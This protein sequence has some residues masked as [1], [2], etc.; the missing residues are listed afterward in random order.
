MNSSTHLLPFCGRGLPG[1]QITHAQCEKVLSPLSDQS[2][3]RDTGVPKPD[4]LISPLGLGLA[5]FIGT[6]TAKTGLYFLSRFMGYQALS[7]SDLV[8]RSYFSKSKDYQ[9]HLRREKTG[10]LS[11]GPQPSTPGLLP[12][13]H[14]ASATA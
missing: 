9:A 10:H 7:L 8:L 5:E 3:S 11:L 12:L 6:T 2:I 4:S 13:F 1:L 14:V